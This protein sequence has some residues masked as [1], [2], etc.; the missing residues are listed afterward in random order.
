MEEEKDEATKARLYAVRAP[1]AGLVLCALPLTS[2]LVMSDEEFRLCVRMRLGVPPK[3]QP[4]DHCRACSRHVDFQLD[5]WHA[6]NCAAQTGRAVTDRH[7]AV[8]DRVCSWATSL[9]MREPRSESRGVDD[10]ERRP[11]I[12]VRVGASTYLLD[13]TVRNPTAPSNCKLGAKG[14]LAVAKAA[15]QEKVAKYKELAEREKTAFVPFAIESFGGMGQAA[16]RFVCD[17]IKESR[18]A[19]VSWAPWEVIYGLQNTIAVTVARGNAAIVRRSLA[20][21]RRLG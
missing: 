15:E 6:I 1:K 13:V 7:N 16:S 17:V 11:D 2:S 8:V 9:G 18:K 14:S 12:K 3:D 21:N 5:P 20:R 19:M 10:D 4:A